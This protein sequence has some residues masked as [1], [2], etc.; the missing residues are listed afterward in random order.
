MTR[1]KLILPAMLLLAVGAAGFV[2]GRRS[3]PQ[4]THVG[5]RVDTLVIRDTITRETPR[6]TRVYV[7]DSI[8]VTVRDTL[9]RTDTVWLPREVKVYEDERYRAE[10][11]GYQPNLDRIDIFVKDRI[12]TQDKTQVVTVKRNARW[13]IGLQVGYGA[14]LNDRRIQGTPYIGVG[15]S[16]NILTF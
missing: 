5:T 15:L 4:I 3:M 7:R 10:V 16:W 8:Y 9:H 6:F 11:S 1:K 14:I 12:V 13:G 2:L